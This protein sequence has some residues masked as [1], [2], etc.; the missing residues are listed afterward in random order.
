MVSGMSIREMNTIRQRVSRIKGGK[1]AKLCR[2]KT[3]VFYISDVPNDDIS[4]VGSGPF[5]PPLQDPIEKI[6]SKYHLEKKIPKKL[7]TSLL[8]EKPT[9]AVPKV[10]HY[11]VGN[12][13]TALNSIARACGASGLNYRIFPDFLKGSAE[14]TGEKIG[15]MCLNE[16]KNGPIA[17]IMGGETYVN[18]ENS[19]GKGGRSQE[20][21]L[22][23]LKTIKDTPG[24]T[25]L[26]AGTD[27]IDGPTDAAGAVV[28][29]GIYQ[30]SQNMGLPI[31][32]YLENH[33]SYNFH[34]KCGSLLKTGPTGTNVCDVAI[35]FIE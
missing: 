26:C 15:K 8:H 32:Q 31:Y 34:E 2:A 4:I 7:I 33:D 17:L 16:K 29:A 35:A 23:I 19:T 18:S 1:L 6:I 20:T 13:R 21:A 3:T 14:S 30:K 25:C 9:I 12:N 11:V 24:I 27:G 28:N 22:S 10:P 5:A